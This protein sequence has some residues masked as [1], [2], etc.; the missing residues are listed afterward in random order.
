VK[1]QGGGREVFL[2]REVLTLPRGY[3]TVHQSVM[4]FGWDKL[5]VGHW[6]HAVYQGMSCKR[7]CKGLLADGR[8][9]SVAADSYWHGTLF[10]ASSSAALHNLWRRIPNSAKA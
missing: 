2:G 9:L 10:G 5:V 7:R 3:V 8:Q 6:L 4:S 1:R